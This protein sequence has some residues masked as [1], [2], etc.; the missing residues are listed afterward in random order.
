MIFDFAAVLVLLTFVSGVIWLVDSLFFAE[1]RNQLNVKEGA[2]ALASST[3]TPRIPGQNVRGKASGEIQGIH[4]PWFVEYARS[5]FPIFLFVLALRSFI[6]EPFRIPSAS[7]MPTLLIGDFILVNKYDYGIRLPV[8]NTKIISN[9]A[10]RRGDIVVFRYPADP[11]IPY[12]KRVVGLPGD[13]IAYY[14]KVLYINGR[15]MPQVELELYTGRGAG[16]I[17][18][19]AS[20]RVEEIETVRHDILVDKENYTRG[21]TATV[22]DGQYF[23][24]GDN[25]DN[26]KDSR[27]WGYVPDKNLIG[28]AF[29][30]WMNWDLKGGGIN[31]KRIGTM[32]E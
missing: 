15:A 6:A 26:S 2:G 10:P 31:W 16:A 11:R 18:N 5:L 21:F 28:R 20:H 13:Q 24:L 27:Y 3:S 32:L 14:D 23:V 4:P 8:I 19:G 29:L 9:K 25:R 22:P 7:M 12:I 17:M 1:Q 30:I